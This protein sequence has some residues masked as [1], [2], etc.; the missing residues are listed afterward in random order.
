[1]MECVVRYFNTLVVKLGKGGGANHVWRMHTI[2]LSDK[3][4]PPGG[5]QGPWVRLCHGPHE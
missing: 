3:C 4:P 5:P 1:M 2:S